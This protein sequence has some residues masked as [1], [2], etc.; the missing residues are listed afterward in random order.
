ML[1]YLCLIVTNLSDLDIDLQGHG[2]KYNHTTR[3]N[4]YF[5][6]NGSI[7]PNSSSLQDIRP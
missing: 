7:W 3:L 4:I 2:V 5:M 1:S 6:F